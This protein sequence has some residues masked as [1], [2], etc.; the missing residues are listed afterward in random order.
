MVINTYILLQSL[1]S[2]EEGKKV[3]VGTLAANKSLNRY[4]NIT[5]CE[6]NNDIVAV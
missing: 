6:L 4:K 3:N 2:G 1:I 5:A